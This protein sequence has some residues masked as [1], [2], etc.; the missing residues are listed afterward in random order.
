MASRPAHSLS[1]VGASGIDGRPP[2][3]DQ[4]S[5]CE[6]LGATEASRRLEVHWS[7]FVTEATFARIAAMG[8][9][10]VRLPYGAW[11]FGDADASVCPN[12]TSQIR[13]IDDAVAWAEKYNISVLLDMH[14]PDG[15]ANGADN[16][17]VS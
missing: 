7:T 17:G 1:V 12:V 5:Y 10:A 8:L 14:G 2:V 6:R 13:Y 4:A 16:T 11:V 3:V 15:G 9:N